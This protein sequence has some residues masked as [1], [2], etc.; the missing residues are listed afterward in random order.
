MI[1][2]AIPK[3]VH[4]IHCKH[5]MHNTVHCQCRHSLQ[6]AV[7]TIT[8]TTNTT[9]GP[10]PL[11]LP[12]HI[13]SILNEWTQNSIISGRKG[14]KQPTNKKG[15]KHD[16]RWKWTPNNNQ[17]SEE[18]WKKFHIKYNSGNNWLNFKLESNSVAFWLSI[19]RIFCLW[20]VVVVV[21]VCIVLCLYILTSNHYLFI[22]VV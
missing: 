5:I 14:K 17:M 22:C 12:P 15:E 18:K 21:V 3:Y 19:G 7:H 9:L 10:Q 2:E 8:T 1:G 13:F 6:H 16:E 11:P 20:F 4:C